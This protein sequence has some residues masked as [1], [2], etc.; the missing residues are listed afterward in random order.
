[1]TEYNTWNKHWGGSKKK[2]SGGAW[3]G[4]WMHCAACAA[5]G[6]KSWIYKTK[7]KDDQNL[8][9][10]MCQ[11]AWAQNFN[12]SEVKSAV[13][14]SDEKIGKNTGKFE[15]KEGAMSKAVHTRY[16]VQTSGKGARLAIKT[17]EWDLTKKAG[18]DL[19]DQ[20]KISEAQIIFEKVK[21]EMAAFAEEPEDFIEQEPFDA[22]DIKKLAGEQH[23]VQNE[24]E[25]VMDNMMRLE[26]DL[27]KAKQK[28]VKLLQAG[29]MIKRAIDEDHKA[30]L[31]AEEDAINLEGEIPEEFVADAEDLAIKAKI[32]EDEKAAKALAQG[33]A[34]RFAAY[35]DLLA[36]KAKDAHLDGP[37]AKK[38]KPELKTAVAATPDVDVGGPCAAQPSG[39]DATRKEEREEAIRREEAACASARCAQELI[40]EEDK[41]K[42]QTAKSKSTGAS[43]PGK[44]KGKGQQRG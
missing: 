40:A 15:G 29:I 20:G 37:N 4:P 24:A 30:K 31:K 35:R 16:F 9:C 21:L 1:M 28:H 13:V 17:E 32:I 42:A 43:K 2:Q 44:Q 10:T 38:P 14:T 33:I 5:A 23:R 36:Q 41:E 6:K 22:E 7:L 26:R 18:K 39:E 19:V 12:N 8:T 3:K 27:A 11:T 25:Q 34:A